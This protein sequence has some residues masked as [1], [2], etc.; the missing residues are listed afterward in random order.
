MAN[1]FD[2]ESKG[3]KPAPREKEPKSRSKNREALSVSEATTGKRRLY[4]MVEE[5]FQTLQNAM[6]EADWPTA[7]KAAQVVLDRAGFGPKSTLDVNTLN[8]DLSNLSKDQL[9]D[10]AQKVSEILRNRKPDTPPS[11][12]PPAP[13][14]H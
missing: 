3:P 11:D 7:I 8:I 9:A 6:S 12:A 5:A 2:P 14:I 4:E 13:G 10:R 1:V